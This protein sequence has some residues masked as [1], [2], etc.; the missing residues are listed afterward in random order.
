MRPEGFRNDWRFAGCSAAV[1][2]LAVTGPA[3]AAAFAFAA[4]VGN[5]PLTIA[6]GAAGFAVLAML[7]LR[8][9]VRDRNAER[10]SAGE[11]IAGLRAQ[12]DL[13]EALLSASREVVVLWSGQKT[14]ARVFGQA[15]ALLPAGRRPEAILDFGQWLD[16]GEIA[17]LA[18]AVE[19]LRVLGHSFTLDLV[20]RDGTPVRA[21]GNALGVGAVMR[22]RSLAA[23]PATLPATVPAAAVPPPEAGLAEAQALLAALDLP[24]FL[25]DPDGR[26]AYA[27]PAYERLAAGLRRRGGSGAPAELLDPAGLQRHLAAVAAAAGPRRLALALPQ[28]PHELVEIGFAGGTAGFLRPAPA[29]AAPADRDGRAAALVAA[30]RQPVAIFDANQALVAFNAAYAGLWKF[31]AWLR[32]GLDEKSV[33]DRLRR[34][35]LL[36]SDPDYQGWR[37]RHLGAYALKGPRTETWH[38]PD[39][40]TLEVTAAP[41][42]PEGGVIYLFEDLSRELELVS[43]NRALLSVQRSTLNALSDAVAVFGTNGRL[44]LFNPRLSALW[45]LPINFLQENPHID[46]VAEAAARALPDDG[47]RIWRD[48]KRAVIDLSPTRTD[49]SGRLT[50][51]DGRLLDYGVVRLPDGQ[52]LVT[53]LDVTESANYSRVLKERNDALVTADRLKDAFVQNVS[54][55]LRSPLTNIIGFADLLATPEV[56]P[57]NARQRAYTDYIRASSVTLGVLIDNILD[58]ATVDAGI[59]EL[60]PEPQDVTALVEKARAGLAATF[61]E[62][63]G[64]TSI[65]LKVSI[66]PDLPPFVADGTRLVQVLYNLLST[67][68]RFSAPGGEVRLSVMARGE[69]MV[70][71][72][73]DDGAALGEQLR[74]AVLD[75]A[76]GA[77]QPGRDRGAGLGLAIVRAF[78]N[79]HGGTITTDRTASGGTR[80]VVSL[81]RDAAQT[82]SAAE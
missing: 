58:L 29:A 7:A 27:N 82:A 76:Q 17:R 30:L 28:G 70:F 12:L 10:R 36:P 22:L 41:A 13:Y 8:R 66:A 4:I 65:N 3:S 79:L 23:P 40:R 77:G 26:L 67:A 55:E 72:V 32:P 81:P 16:D 1:L 63:R 75:G 80:V 50:R 9:V 39:G 73:E 21:A 11:T 2:I 56:G 57:L 52:K 38:L 14:G 51:A 25:R 47:A 42:G 33:L 59:A 19:A 37:Q 62:I 31:D 35:G 49:L 34:D 53:F 68:A 45:K 60:R 15:L 43:Q 44:Q 74:E 64:G 5:A 71:T 20:C 69:R 61:P 54:Y 18:P 24:A 78:V 46:Q 6:L 48:L